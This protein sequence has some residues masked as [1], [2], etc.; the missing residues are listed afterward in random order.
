MKCQEHTS[1]D[2]RDTDEKVLCSP[3]KV[4]LIIDRIQTAL[5]S[6]Y[7]MHGNFEVLSSDYIMSMEGVIEMKK[8]FDLHVKCPSLLTDCNQTYSVHGQCAE[9]ARYEVSVTSLPV[10][11]EILRKK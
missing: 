3:S 7:K 6:L 2:R 5:K 11:G 4:P 10:E 1:I 8:Y 9:S